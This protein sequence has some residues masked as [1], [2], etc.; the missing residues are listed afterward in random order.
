ME[1]VA[2]LPDNL[3]ENKSFYKF[4]E[5]FRL[6]GFLNISENEFYSDI[7]GTRFLILNF[8]EDIG[9]KFGFHAISYWGR[10]LRL[11]KW[12]KKGV[13]IV[14][15]VNNK[16][17]HDDNA[18]WSIRM[19]K[20]LVKK[21]YKIICL[22]KDSTE[23]LRNLVSDESVWKEKLV[24][25]PHPNYEGAYKMP[26][27]ISNPEKFTALFFGAI[28]PYKNVVTL[29]RT[30]GELPQDKVHLIVA[31]GVKNPDYEKYLLALAKNFPSVDLRLGYVNDD[32]I[33]KLILESSVVVLPYDNKTTLNS[34]SV[35]LCC[36]AGKTFISPMIGTVKDFP[37]SS[38]FYP[39]T[40]ET[41]EEHRKAL[42]ENILKAFN[43]FE[44]DSQSFNQKG[45]KLNEYVH[46]EHSSEKLAAI[47]KREIR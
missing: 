7:S 37:D 29:I 24:L 2:W 3:N 12:I 14:W 28:R 21:A 18:K 22:C 15:V 33:M 36:T 8:F 34:G 26:E 11:K 27:K 31:G 35:L 44:R 46:N 13:K 25:L 39:Y 10:F 19:Q 9:K 16:V 23:V 17:P 41:E 30:F 1:R 42:K 45:Q 47:L 38:L 32:E 20:V 6:A 40:Y 5:A 4:K 43:D